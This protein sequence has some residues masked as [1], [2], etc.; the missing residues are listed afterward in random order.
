MDHRFSQKTE[1][2]RKDLIV[3]GF[4]DTRLVIEM[5]VVSPPFVIDFAKSNVNTE[6]ARHC[7]CEALSKTCNSIYRLLVHERVKQ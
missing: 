6:C 1:G 2:M 5:S 4:D 3:L 7:F